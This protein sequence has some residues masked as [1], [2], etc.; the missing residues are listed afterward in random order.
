VYG[1]RATRTLCCFLGQSVV[2]PPQAGFRGTR[3][4]AR[5]IDGVAASAAELPPRA[6]AWYVEV[7]S[8]VRAI[9]SMQAPAPWNQAP[10]LAREGNDPGSLFAFPVPWS[11]L[12]FLSPF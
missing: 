9:E 7:G 8:R 11:Q 10:A 3:V 4:L 1:S 2:V 5:R 12:S 6:V